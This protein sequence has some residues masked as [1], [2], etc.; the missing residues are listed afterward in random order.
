V[1]NLSRQRPVFRRLGLAVLLLVAASGAWGQATV[2]GMNQVSSTR[3]GRTTYD[4]TYTINVTNGATGLSNAVATVTSSAAATTIVQ[5]SVAL[6]TLA[7]GANITSTNTF[8]LQQ[9]R[10]VA[11][12]P[13]S[14]SWAV[15]GIAFDVVPN[16]VGLMQAAASSTITGAGLTVGA[17]T[18]QS[19]TSIASGRIIS[20]TPTVGADVAPGSAVNL[21]AS[22]GPAMVA[23]PNVTGLS[24]SAADAAL[25]AAG[26]QVGGVTTQGSSTVPSGDVISEGPPA[27]TQVDVGSAVSLVVSTAPV[28]V[29]VPNV[30][31]L[32]QASATTT[33]TG[34]TLLVGTV[35]MNSSSTIAAGDVISESPSAGTSVSP[36][37]SVSLVVST[38]PATVAV[39]NVVNLTLAGATTAVDGAGLVVGSTTSQNSSTVPSGEVISESPAAGSLVVDGSAVNLVISAGA[40]AYPG[41]L[42]SGN[43]NSLALNATTNLGPLQSAAAAIPSSGSGL[44]LDKIDLYFTPTATVGQVNAAIQSVNGS[45]SAMAAGAAAVVVQIPMAP[46]AA[47]LQQTA[48]G[49]AAMPGVLAAN[50]GIMAGDLSLPAPDYP[51]T[52]NVQHLAAARFPAAFSVLSNPALGLLITCPAQSQVAVIVADSFDSDPNASPPVLS[53]ALDFPYRLPSFILETFYD[54]NGNAL[55]N[56]VS[57]SDHGNKVSMILAAIWSQGGV[58]SSGMLG[59]APACVTVHGINA[60]GRSSLDVAYAIWFVANRLI[61][62]D[63]SGNA[64]GPS[65]IVNYSRKDAPNSCGIGASAYSPCSSLSSAQIESGDYI[66]RPAARALTALAWRALVGKPVGTS[67]TDYWQRILTVPAAGNEYNTPASSLYPG[68]QVGTMESFLTLAGTSTDLLALIQDSKLWGQPPGEDQGGTYPDLTA[69]P[70]EAVQIGTLESNLGTNLLQAGSTIV[71]GALSNYLPP[72]GTTLPRLDQWL[73][74]VGAWVNANGTGGGSNEL[75]TAD[76]SLYAVGSNIASSCSP[77]YANS[78]LYTGV[79]CSISTGTSDAAPQVSG[80]AALLWVVEGALVQ[81]LYQGDQT[82][83]LSSS[84]TSQTVDLLTATA[85]PL[86]ATGSPSEAMIDALA[87]V[88]SLDPAQAVTAASSPVRKYLLD[89]NQDGVFNAADVQAFVQKYYTDTNRF[90][91]KQIVPGATPDFSSFD[92]NGDGYTGVWTTT[93]FD[94]DPTGSTQRGAPVLN[95]VSEK[96]TDGHT[97][98]FDETAV[99]DLDVMCYYAYSGLFDASTDMSGAIRDTLGCDAVVIMAESGDTLTGGSDGAL[100]QTIQSIDSKVSVNKSGAIAFSVANTNNTSA[101]A[102]VDVAHS[103]YPISFSPSSNRTYGGASLNDAPAVPEAAFVDQIAGA[104]PVT[105]VRRWNADGSAI[106]TDIATSAGGVSFAAATD[107]VDM[108]DAGVAVFAALDP[109]FTYEQLLAGDGLPGDLQTLASF[110]DGPSVRFRPQIASTNDAVYEDGNGNIVVTRY[111]RSGAGTPRVVAPAS[112]YSAVS[113]RPGISA[114]G[115]WVAFAGSV[116]APSAYTGLYLAVATP[117]EAEP[118]YTVTYNGANS[119]P[120]LYTGPGGDPSTTDAQ[121]NSFGVRPTAGSDGTRFGIAAQP[122]ADGSGTNISVVFVAQ[123]AYFDPLTH[124]PTT[125]VYGVY[126]LTAL[127]SGAG[128]ATSYSNVQIDPIVEVGDILGDGIG[129]NR[130]VADFDL[131]DPVSKNGMYA[132]FWVQFVET[133]PSGTAIQGVVRRR[134]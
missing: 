85:R 70:E 63:A 92:L 76:P 59:A 111:N 17:V 79:P 7:A 57:V 20:E 3:V 31:G 78:S 71:A 114:D 118:T 39:P 107:Y 47:T 82:Q 112:T 89:V 68:V 132:G 86:P 134:L 125:T 121:F 96:L 9:D 102:R 100:S 131:W 58:A 44:L 83:L 36:G 74:T 73:D 110:T 98:H 52:E 14:L 133:T 115:N 34:D 54:R 41:T 40:T 8:T 124:L 24:E 130:T 94:L 95:V 87:A 84:P 43:P 123:R 108:N 122:A 1:S 101:G 32:S 75:S 106:E 16:V 37:S 26:L 10:T 72:P 19:S 61:A 104:P 99:S 53:Q 113:D 116:T 105:Y 42:L 119:T 48:Q 46:D 65:V 126:H 29:T 129:I 62:V 103:A 28:Q 23:V 128:S 2:T 5:G 60:Y 77:F 90:I 38:G 67:G 49:L 97:L 11:F 127:A 64:T 18:Q 35:S 66:G 91:A 93:T 55:P 80:L 30:V 12:N 22:S 88:L 13:A 21:V 33:I 25:V 6:G 109:T 56:T 69:T 4:Y 15:T 117:G 81:P 45:I 120:L 27:G 50:P 51:G